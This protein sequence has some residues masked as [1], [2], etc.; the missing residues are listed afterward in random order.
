MLTMS[1]RK[2]FKLLHVGWECLNPP[3]CEPISLV[4]AK[5]HCRRSVFETTEDSIIGGYVTGARNAAETDS[6]RA[7]C[8]QRWKMILDEWPDIIEGFKCPLIDIEE[9][10][11]YDYTTPTAQR[12]VV[13]PATYVVSTTEPWRV[14][15]AFTKFW[16]PQRPQMGSIEVTF[17][18]GYLIPFTAEASGNTLT[19]QDYTPTNGD[20]FR[21]SN[22]G[23]E[24]PGALSA[25]VTYW[26]VG[27]SSHT[28]QLSLTAGGAAIDLTS[29]G[30]GLQFLGTLPGGLRMAM[31]KHIATN[32]AD[33]EGSDAAAR[34]QESYLQSLRAVQYSVM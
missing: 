7:V 1:G 21:V 33:R 9:A 23:G 20:S 3:T 11:Y 12:L 29:A 4:E 14:N 28:C 32:F 26:I 34:C 22:S 27:S 24:L 16:Q 25:G 2:P 18:A 31:L 19:F 15:L 13:A 8:W 17:T 10:A 5:Q 30:S 6:L